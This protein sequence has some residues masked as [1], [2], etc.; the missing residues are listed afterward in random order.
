MAEIDF[1]FTDVTK[2]CRSL[3]LYHSFSLTLDTDIQAFTRISRESTTR[4]FIELAS[5]KSN[6]TQVAQ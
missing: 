3:F 1:G 2:C 5:C 4:L 6:A